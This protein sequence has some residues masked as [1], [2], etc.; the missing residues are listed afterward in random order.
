MPEEISNPPFDWRVSSLVG[1]QPS[2]HQELKRLMRGYII[3][4]PGLGKVQ[5]RVKFL[6][7]PSVVAVSHSTDAATATVTPQ[8]YRNPLDKG[9]WNI[10]LAASVSF[11]LLFDRTYELWGSNAEPNSGDA[12]QGPER[13]GVRADI[14]ALYRVV[15]ILMPETKIS[16]NSRQTDGTKNLPPTTYVYSNGDPGPM[17]LTPVTVYFGGP[18]SVSYRGYVSSIDVQWT[19]FSQLMVPMR[20]TVGVSMNLMTQNSWET[21]EVLEEEQ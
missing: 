8:N 6:Y 4:D 7:N 21:A 2:V 11:N 19:H 20:C 14:E 15:G 12:T 13:V 16:G 5:Y 9:A 1:L 17:P 10:P 18:N 3:Q